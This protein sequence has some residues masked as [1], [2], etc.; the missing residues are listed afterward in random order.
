[1]TSKQSLASVASGVSLALD[2]ARKEIDT[3]ARI[4]VGLGP[5][6][7]L[8]RGYAIVRDDTDK[9]ITNREAAL[10]QPRL[11]IQFRDGKLAVNNDRCE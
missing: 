5:Q 2:N 1:M 3:L 10:S 9:P 8:N 6:S 11:Q 4:V 7:T